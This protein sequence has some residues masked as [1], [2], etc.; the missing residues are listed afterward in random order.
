MQ[1]KCPLC[2]KDHPPVKIRRK[3]LCAQCDN[4]IVLRM[5]QFKS[6]EK[7]GALEDARDASLGPEAII[8]R[9]LDNGSE[10]WEIIPELLADNTMAAIS[11]S[12]PRVKRAKLYRELPDHA[13][14]HIKEHFRQA[15]MKMLLALAPIMA[16]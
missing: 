8:W 14:A 2:G 10:T 9:K 15:L 1:E 12:E 16:A 6:M 5:R 3:L 4:Q 11:I 13:P 7:A